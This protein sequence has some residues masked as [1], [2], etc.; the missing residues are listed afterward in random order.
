MTTAPTVAPRRGNGIR[1]KSFGDLLDRVASG[2]ARPGPA[3]LYVDGYGRDLILIAFVRAPG[4]DSKIGALKRTAT[5]RRGGTDTRYFSD[6]VG[7]F[8]ERSGSTGPSRPARAR[9]RSSDRFAWHG[10]VYT[11]RIGP[12]GTGGRAFRLSFDARAESACEDGP[13]AAYA[14]DVERIALSLI[15]HRGGAQSPISPQSFRDAGGLPNP[16]RRPAGSL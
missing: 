14:Q 12:A 9:T 16:P 8:V 13:G 2:D 15:S 4:R 5:A 10:W 6:A 11:I 3:R 7:D 1:R